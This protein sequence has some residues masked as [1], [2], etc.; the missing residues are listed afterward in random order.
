MSI[1]QLLLPVIVGI[2]LGLIGGGGTA[3][4]VP[5]LVYFFEQDP[6]S[7]IGMSLG[8]VCVV[9]LVGSLSHL[10]KHNV[11]LESAAF[12]TPFAMLGAF[13]GA[14][15]ATLPIITS[16]VQLVLFS[17]TILFA[18]SIMIL[19]NSETPAMEV[20]LN[21]NTSQF[22]KEDNLTNAKEMGEGVI[23][24][25]PLFESH[26]Q[27]SFRDLS[28]YASTGLFVGILTGL[29]GVGGGFLIVP[30]LVYLAKIPIRQAIGTSLVVIFFNSFSGFLGYLGKV[31]MDWL[32]MAIFIGL[33]LI[34]VVLGSHFSNRMPKKFLQKIFGIFLFLVGIWILSQELI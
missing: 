13:I 24:A 30:T 19:R 32:V 10:K 20:E 18:S 8:I 29:V 21:P 34:G 7:A 11:R 22:D 27:I 4:A 26:F 6:K 33:A 28:Q 16:F 31:E 2:S 14:K 17:I 1:I 23:D 3:L 15:I 25:K 9:S 12:F 5:V